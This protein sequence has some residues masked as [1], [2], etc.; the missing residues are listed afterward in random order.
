[1]GSEGQRSEE[2][3]SVSRWEE[4]R[5]WLNECE[6]LR[7]MRLSA[8]GCKHADSP[9]G[10]LRRVLATQDE[11]AAE[12]KDYGRKH[13]ANNRR[14]EPTQHNGKKSL[15]VGKGTGLLV[16]SDTVPPAE[17]EGKAHDGANCGWRWGMKGLRGP[18]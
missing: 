12:D 16:P 2:E 5:W 1:M 11:G 14:E 13:T 4:R 10:F 6:K 9:Y 15:G 3:Q 7:G 8:Q 17:Y 18:A